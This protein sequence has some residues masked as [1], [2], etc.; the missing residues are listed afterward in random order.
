[1]RP[2]QVDHDVHLL[3]ARLEAFHEVRLVLRLLALELVHEDLQRGRLHLQPWVALEAL[4]GDLGSLQRLLLLTYVKQ[5]LQCNMQRD[6]LLVGLGVL[7]RQL[8]RLQR[9]PRRDASL[10]SLEG[11]APHS[12]GLQLCDL[13][14]PIPNVAVD[15]QRL[16]GRL[17]RRCRV[18]LPEVRQAGAMQ[19]HALALAVVHLAKELE[20]LLG[21]LVHL[22]RFL[23]L[24]Q[25]VHHHQHRSCLPKRLAQLVEEPD[26]LLAP[27]LGV[28]AHLVQRP[29]HVQLHQGVVQHPLSLQAVGRPK[30][31]ELDLAEEVDIMGLQRR[32]PCRGAELA[33]VLLRQDLD[34][35]GLR[36]RVH[37]PALQI[38]LPSDLGLLQCF[39]N[40]AKD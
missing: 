36:L 24:V 34:P 38:I 16:H 28:R 29:C 10:V 8:Q 11:H 27:V 40:L 35:E 7:P 21:K 32:L 25:D 26:G 31:R 12:D 39:K 30:S 22:L 9:L 37:V 5:R 17:H 23:E 3:L 2:G 18:A 14:A 1:M 13:Q 20:R 19:R 15:G 4:Q 33:I 6:C